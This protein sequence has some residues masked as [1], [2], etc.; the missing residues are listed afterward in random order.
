MANKGKSEPNF[1]G[2][3]THYDDKGHKIGH[4]DPGFFGYQ[5]SDSQGCYIA[6]CAYGSHGCPAVWILRRFRDEIL[7]QSAAGR[8]FIGCYYALS[9]WVVL[10]FGETRWFRRFWRRRLD[11]LVEKLRSNGLGDTPYQNKTRRRHA[12]QIT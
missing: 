5:N 2:G 9:P 6:T 1:F 11:R 12:C 3:Y 7:A 4:S 8:A 10:R